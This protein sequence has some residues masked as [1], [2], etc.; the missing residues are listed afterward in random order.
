MPYIEVF[1]ILDMFW[2]DIQSSG[3]PQTPE[4]K[5]T[6]FKRNLYPNRN[7]A[8]ALNREINIY[9]SSQNSLGAKV[10]LLKMLNYLVNVNTHMLY[11][12]S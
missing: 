12:F 7:L 4:K 11:I 1:I 8:Y 10:K 9:M 2:G 3:C 6:V 5:T